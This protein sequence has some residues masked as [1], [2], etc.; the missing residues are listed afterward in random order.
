MTPEQ[1]TK[2]A[3]ANGCTFTQSNEHANVFKIERVPDHKGYIGHATLA[4]CSEL[5]FIEFYI[6][7]PRK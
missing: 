1:A 7:E 3:E 5:T 2:I 4:V 6:P